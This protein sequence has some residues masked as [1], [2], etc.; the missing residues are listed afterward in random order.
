MER[1]VALA[2][3][4]DVGLIIQQDR[5]VLT[6]ECAALRSVT[7]PA[8]GR[9]ADF[10]V[11]TVNDTE[12][13]TSSVFR[14]ALARDHSQDCAVTAN[15]NDLQ[16]VEISPSG[17][18]EHDEG[19]QVDIQLSRNGLEDPPRTIAVLVEKTGTILGGT[20]SETINIDFADG[21]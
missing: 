14:V 15:D 1:A 7:V 4:L 2:T 13:E 10:R 21:E 9:S 17:I 6:A 5:D 8:R 19:A 18:T 12:D 20:S 11:R 16:S 3:A